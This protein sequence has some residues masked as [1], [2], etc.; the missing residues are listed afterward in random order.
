MKKYDKG[1]IQNMRSQ[2][3]LKSESEAKVINHSAKAKH[4]NSKIQTTKK[5]QEDWYQIVRFVCFA[6]EG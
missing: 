3:K 4:T 6:K 1:R 2:K 5:S